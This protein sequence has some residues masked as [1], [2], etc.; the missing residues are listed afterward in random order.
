MLKFDRPE[1]KSGV[2]ICD[3]VIWISDKKLE[4]RKHTFYTKDKGK[5]FEF[6]DENQMLQK[7]PHLFKIKS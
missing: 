1:F 6:S 3:E 2:I 5:Y 7:Y 4:I